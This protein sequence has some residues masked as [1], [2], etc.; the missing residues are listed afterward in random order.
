MRNRWWNPEFVGGLSLPL[1]L[2][3]GLGANPASARVTLPQSVEEV[4]LTVRQPQWAPGRVKFTP[5]RAAYQ[6]LFR[7]GSA[8]IRQFPLPDGSWVDLE[9]VS[10]DLVNGG[11]RFF[12]RDADGIHEKSRPSM[13]FFRGQV[14]G[15]PESLVSLTLFR[16]QVAGFVRTAGSTY[17]FGPRS[18]ADGVGRAGFIEVRDDAAETEPGG[19]CNGDELSPEGDELLTMG[20]SRYFSSQP[21]QELTIDGDTL[22]LAHVA[23][24]G[25]VEWVNKHG[26]VAGAEAYTLNL[27]A[28]VSAIYESDFKVQLQ[29]PFVLMNSAEPDGYSGGGNSTSTM[30]SEMVTNWNGSETLRNVFRTTAHVFSTYPSGGAGRA[31]LDVLCDGVPANSNSYDFG[32][33]LLSGNG[34]S[35]ERGLVAH[36]LG[37]NFS[38][39]HTHCYQPEI[40]Q[41]SGGQAGCYSGPDIPTTGTIMSYCSTS[42]D[43]FHQRVRDEQL[44]PAAEAAFPS[45]MDVAGMPGSIGAAAGAGLDISPARICNAQSLQADSGSPSSSL[46]Y[47]GSAM[48]AWVKRFTPDCYPFKLTDVQVRMVNTSSLSPGR[49]LRILIYTDPGGTGSPANAT[50]VHSEDT[51]IQTVGGSQWNQYALATPVTLTAGDFYIGFHDLDPDSGST[52]IMDYDNGSSGDSWLQANGTSP[53]GY[54]SFGNGT[55][56]IRGQGGGVDA[57]SL[58]MTW[59]LPCNAGSVPNQDY[60]VYQGPLGDW[61]NLSILTCS[62]GYDRSALIES[63]QPNM[64]WL[65][66]PQNS[67]NEGSYG[68]SS[69]GERSPAAVPCKP[70]AIAACP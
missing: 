3:L 20:A 67:A 46:G 23:V 63:I 32:V 34:G 31:Y 14:A 16:G 56:M 69:Y 38:S 6:T 13:R 51:T 9:V 39:S 64:F 25:T 36:E 60:A 12:V 54:S 1:V 28:Q 59:G 8:R 19:R 52:Y 61:S 18:F 37:H 40:D 53:G 11:T 45:C 29:V 68:Q 65:I 58:S 41:C 55:W 66:V 15:E 70:Q 22:L 57:G 5:D 10:S 48:A 33:S 44:R 26:G 24:E 27:M 42:L 2:C 43:T 30:L 7:A 50:L 62:T 35:W 21:S 47:G 4:I 17:T 49:P